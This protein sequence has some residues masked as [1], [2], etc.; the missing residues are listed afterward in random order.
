[1]QIK[2]MAKCNAGPKWEEA[3]ENI[4]QERDDNNEGGGEIDPN[5]RMKKSM[6]V[7]RLGK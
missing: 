4:A 5:L 7:S 6:G 3:S 1:M 2:W